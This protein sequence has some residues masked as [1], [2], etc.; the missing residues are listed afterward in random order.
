LQSDHG[1]TVTQLTDQRIG[2][3]VGANKAWQEARAIRSE[4]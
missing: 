2:I 4:R 1:P 3:T